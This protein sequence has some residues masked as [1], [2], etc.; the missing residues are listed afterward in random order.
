MSEALTLSRKGI[1]EGVAAILAGV[2]GWRERRVVL[3][4]VQP[5]FV[6]LGGR[7]KRQKGR[8]RCGLP[9][10]GS[11]PK[12]PLFAL[13]VVCPSKAL[14]LAAKIVYILPLPSSLPSLIL[15]S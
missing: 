13:L 9:S 1:E 15:D 14:V 6:V 10:S 7:R 5:P 2:W 8:V 11:V 3:L 4:R 12:Q